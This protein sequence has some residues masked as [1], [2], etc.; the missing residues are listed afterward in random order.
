[1]RP[2]STL[3]LACLAGAAAATLVACSGTNPPSGPETPPS[4]S[5]GS[6]SSP[7]AATGAV[8]LDDSFDAGDVNGWTTG[9]D[10]SFGTITYEDGDQRWKFTGSVASWIP[11]TL[12][13]RFDG[14][15][16]MDGTVVTTEVT[17]VTGG[18]V[19]GVMCRNAPDTDAG[20]QWYEFVVRD[21]YA[22]IRKSD[23][24]HH[25]E[26]LA[27][28]EDVSVA[29]GSPVQIEG[30]CV[31]GDDGAAEL[32]MTVDGG[33]LLTARDDEPIPDGPPG[34]QVWTAPV[35]S[36]QELLWHSFTVTQA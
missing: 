34:M 12:L 32:E 15:E 27:E 8:I 2:P 11:E 26:P 28:T 13:T 14:G 18:G 21:G 1:M 33:V 22:A 35:H 9:L 17:P 31:T 6:G 7:V 25:I 16:S 19:F 5:G 29:M 4:P 23:D 10:T 24:H 36:L 20:Y 3:A 30:R